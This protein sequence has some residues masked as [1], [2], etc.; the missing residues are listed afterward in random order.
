MK[1]ETGTLP[2]RL[3]T[4]GHERFCSI[5]SRSVFEVLGAASTNFTGALESPDSDL[6]Q[7]MVKDPYVFEHLALIE[8]VDERSVEQAPMD[9][10]TDTLL[11]LG[12]G[13]AFVGRQ[14][15]FLVPDD[16]PGGP[17][18]ELVADL[19]LS[20][21]PAA[22]CRDRASRWATSPRPAWGSLG[23]YVA[24][25][26]DRLRGPT[27]HAATVGIPR[28]TGKHDPWCG[29]RLP[30]SAL[31]AV[32]EF[33]DCRPVQT[34][35]EWRVVSCRRRRRTVLN[36]RGCARA[37]PPSRAIPPKCPSRGRGRNTVIDARDDRD[38]DAAQHGRGPEPVH[39]M[40]QEKWPV[41]HEQSMSM[42][43]VDDDAEQP[44]REDVEDER[45]RLDEWLDEQLDDGQHQPDHEVD[46]QACC[47]HVSTCVTAIPPMEASATHTPTAAATVR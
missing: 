14:V 13:M 39:C 37:R 1:S 8:R 29:T 25:V 10:L 35:P 45:Q 20:H 17:A 18:A 15:R 31:V 27:H 30:T 33:Q 24:V 11:E 6:A 36:G 21:L 23:T 12:R 28:C 32:A 43:G 40:P 22:V 4:A 44:Q 19:L 16:K 3:R 46:E 9:R 26:D 7:Q 5:R 47:H 41:S 42:E 34:L 2:G 38:D